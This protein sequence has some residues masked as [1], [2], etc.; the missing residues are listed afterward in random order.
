MKRLVFIPL[1]FTVF[2]ACNKRPATPVEQGKC[3][4]TC[5]LDKIGQFAQSSNI[6]D[7]TATVKRY[8][9]QDQNVYLFDQGTCGNDLTIP[10]LNED[11]DTLGYLGGIMGNN[12]IN[13]Q[14]FYANASYV[15][16]VWSN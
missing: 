2:T 14:D 16:T 5:I 6:C 4:V 10:V 15:S 13:G 3:G 9:F 12:T 1:L 11:C 8:S 7:S